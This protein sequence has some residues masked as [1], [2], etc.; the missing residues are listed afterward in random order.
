MKCEN[1]GKPFMTAAEGE[2]H[3][4]LGHLV[5]TEPGEQL[6]FDSAIEDVKDKRKE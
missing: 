4:K 2:V 1:C 3:L 5:S 6:N